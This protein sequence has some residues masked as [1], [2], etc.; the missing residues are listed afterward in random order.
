LLY[1]DDEF[2]NLLA[3]KSQFRRDFE[4]NCAEDVTTALWYLE[5]NNID[6]VFTDQRMPDMLGTDFLSIVK[7]QFPHV[8]RIII[9]GFAEDK[10][11]KQALESGLIEE[12]YEKPFRKNDLIAC[13]NKRK[14]ETSN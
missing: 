14:D 5:N 6:F 8:H 7:E 1:V 9:S 10:T 13:I 12:V 4:V 11:I 2:I 3:F